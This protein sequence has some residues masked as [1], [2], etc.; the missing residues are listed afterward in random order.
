MLK[1]CQTSWVEISGKAGKVGF[2]CVYYK[3]HKRKTSF[4]QNED[5]EDSY[6]TCPEEKYHN[7]PEQMGQTW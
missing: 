2:T 3:K 6:G 5:V 1:F 7:V 4:E